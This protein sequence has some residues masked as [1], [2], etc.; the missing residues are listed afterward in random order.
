[1]YSYFIFLTASKKNPIQNRL[2]S[3]SKNNLITEPNSGVNIVAN[4]NL[5]DVSQKQSVIFSENID[6][7]KIAGFRIPAIAFNLDTIEKEKLKDELKKQIDAN[8]SILNEMNLIRQRVKTLENEK[9]KIQ[10]DFEAN[11]KIWKKKLEEEKNRNKGFRQTRHIF[12]T[13]KS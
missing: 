8:N 2:Q 12:K 6:S 4:Q 3:Q 11:E 1:M 10:N 13:K 7:Q 5:N 9:K